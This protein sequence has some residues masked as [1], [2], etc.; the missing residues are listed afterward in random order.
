MTKI[1]SKGSFK[2]DQEFD[3][4]LNNLRHEWGWGRNSAEGR[5][6]IVEW[7]QDNWPELHDAI[8]D[9]VKEYCR[10]TSTGVF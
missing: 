2:D 8:E 10:R 9:I 7:M 6:E 5:R 1:L 4:A 3:K